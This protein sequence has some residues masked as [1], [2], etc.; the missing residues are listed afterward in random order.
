M[1]PLTCQVTA[2]LE[3]PVIVAVNCAVVPMRVWGTPVTETTAGFGVLELPEQ[4]KV[5]RR[6]VMGEI[7]SRRGA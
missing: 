3:D 1:T 5:S 4:P 7:R 2:K 6:P